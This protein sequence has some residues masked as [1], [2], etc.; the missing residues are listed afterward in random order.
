MQNQPSKKPK[1]YTTKPH[2]LKAPKTKRRGHFLTLRDRALIAE[3]PEP[4]RRTVLQYKGKRVER[5]RRAYKQAYRR[6]WR[7]ALRDA[8]GA[9][10]DLAFLAE[11]AEKDWLHEV[12]T[13]NQPLYEL[14]DDDVES[15]EARAQINV[16][17]YSR[18]PLEA[19]LRTIARRIG[20]ER[21]PVTRVEGDHQVRERGGSFI[22]VRLAA[23][24]EDGLNGEAEQ[25]TH[26]VQIV[27][28][29][30]TPSS[31][32]PSRVPARL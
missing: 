13:E 32:P 27:N 9:L 14:T 3:G 1:D 12:V 21:W 30:A 15:K 25:P 5:E 7:E 8:R 10:L 2:P 20:W 28:R 23:A 16:M 31:W 29:E 11:H 22:V 18:A 24:V 6:V 4:K 17:G 19:L 26:V